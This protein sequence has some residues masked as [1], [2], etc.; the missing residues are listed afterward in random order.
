MTGSREAAPCLDRD[1]VAVIEKAGEVTVK[2]VGWQRP[3][4]AMYK[5][6]ATPQDPRAMPSRRPR[7]ADSRPATTA[8]LVVVIG[9]LLGIACR[10]ARAQ[11]DEARQL[12]QLREN[13]SRLT[14]SIATRQAER[15][16]LSVDLRTSELRLATLRGELARVEAE[17]AN[18][19]DAL[20]GLE[21]ER[22][23]Q[24]QQLEAERV[25]L[26]RQARASFMLL[27]VD[28]LHALLSQ[29]SPA[30][31][32]RSRTYHAYV[33]RARAAQ[34][35]SLR[36]R[37]DAML[38]LEAETTARRTNLAELHASRETALAALEQG[39]AQR[40]AALDQVAADLGERSKRLERLQRDASALAELLA[41]LE[42]EM[43]DLKAEGAETVPF[44]EQ[45][46]KLPWPATGRIDNAYGTPRG[47]TALTWQ[48]VLIR[49][50]RGA[51]VRAISRGRVAFAD[52]LRGFGLMVIV[53][54]GDGFM[55]LYGHND[56]L[57]RETGDWVNV[58]D[59]LGTVGDSGGLDSTGL[60]FE[61]RHAGSPQNP[62]R[63][64]AKR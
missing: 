42:R 16:R 24:Q 62:V 43:A 1:P 63:W 56:T 40:Q 49:A 64:L 18:A 17:M 21:N 44:G 34:I 47:D 61:I 19:G 27:R 32:A 33:T 55:S 23:S 12:Q 50:D 10:P 60:Y 38:R 8:V 46:G 13:I 31:L 14:E 54:H 51:P 15:D 57:A 35:D 3:D 7:H 4:P 37:L 11:E 2:G 20:A 26:S 53:D 36:T 30:A 9:L 52:W 48:G 29:R 25:T 45:R 6:T 39:R 5:H 41:G 58:G 28:Y 22:A 59:V